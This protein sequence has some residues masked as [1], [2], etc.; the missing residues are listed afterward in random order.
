MLILD[1]KKVAALTKVSIQERASFFSTAKK[2]SPGLAVVLIGGDP[3]SQVYV[4]NKIKACEEVGIKSFHHHLDEKVAQPEVVRL[5][6]K[7]NVDPQVD[8][9]LVQLPLPPHLNKDEILGLIDPAKDPDGL[10]AGNLGLLL[11]GQTRVAPCTPQGVIEIL[12]HY[13]IQISGKHAVVVGRSQIVGKPMSLLLLDKNATVTIAHSKTPDLESI[14]RTGDIVVVA[15][16]KARFLGK[17]AFK[18][19]AVVIDVGIHRPKEGLCG[20]VRFEELEG[21]V[22]AATPVPGGVGPMTIAMLLENTLKLAEL[23]SP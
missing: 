22:R 15:A 13:K 4:K 7:L 14:T 20:D 5:I 12:E 11:S 1:G 8:G 9:I 3:G 19:D 16:G 23:R 21:H 2:R 17:S 18:K 10:T 6:Q